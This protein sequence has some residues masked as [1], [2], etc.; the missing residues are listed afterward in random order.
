MQILAYILKKYL[1]GIFGNIALSSYKVFS[2]FITLNN[3][4]FIVLTSKTKF[5]DFLKNLLKNWLLFS[6]TIVQNATKI[7][8]FCFTPLKRQR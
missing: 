5:V 8:K 6:K 3:E 7:Y 1:I 2:K 4:K